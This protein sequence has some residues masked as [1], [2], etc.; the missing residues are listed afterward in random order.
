[1]SNCSDAPRPQVP[2]RRSGSTPSRSGGPTSGG[3]QRHAA[4][5]PPAARARRRRR[6]PGMTQPSCVSDGESHLRLP[7][8]SSFGAEAC[9]ARVRPPDL[10]PPRAEL[11]SHSPRTD[12]GRGPRAARLRAARAA[13]PRVGLVMRVESFGRPTARAARAGAA[14]PLLRTVEE[15]P[16]VRG[17]W[18]S[19]QPT[20]RA[21]LPRPRPRSSLSTPSSLLGSQVRAL[22]DEE[23]RPVARLLVRAAARTA[24]RVI[25][26]QQRRRHDDEIRQTSSYPCLTALLRRSI[27]G[28]PP[29]ATSLRPCAARPGVARTTHGPPSLAQARRP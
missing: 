2:R 1:M 16:P 23:T 11:L 19:S 4:A 10:L 13:R 5:L 25:T 15:P 6:W 27:L 3:A 24:A 7:H 22:A 9:A 20:L 8:V 17:R 12:P 21:T 14:D 26:A 28:V 18:H 29:V